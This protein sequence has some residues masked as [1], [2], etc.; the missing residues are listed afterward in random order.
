M[1][2]IVVLG[3]GVCVGVLAIVFLALIVRRERLGAPLFVP[4]TSLTTIQ[5][6]ENLVA[7]PIP[8]GWRFAFG[9]NRRTGIACIEFAQLLLIL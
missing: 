8:E 3:V 1:W 5:Q 4:L 6:T 9:W 2:A 7:H